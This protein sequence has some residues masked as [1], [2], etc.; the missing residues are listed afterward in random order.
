MKK[1]IFSGISLLFIF[2]GWANAQNVPPPPAPIVESDL[3]DNTIKMRSIDLERVKQDAWKVKPGESTKKRE[4]KFGEIKKN[5]ENIQKLQDRIVRVYTT[6]KTIDYPKISKSALKITKNAIRLDENLFGGNQEDT[7][8]INDPVER[9]S[10]RDLII[11]LDNGIGKFV[12]SPIFQNTKVVDS[13]I[14]SETQL[15][16][17]KIMKLSM[18]LSVVAGNMEN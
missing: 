13:Q 5:F 11:D 7:V 2:A 8:E 6:G 10:V 3:R 18:M 15:E 4:I 17:R 16:L 12:K 9:K 14:S 1:T